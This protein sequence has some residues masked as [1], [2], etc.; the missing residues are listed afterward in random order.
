MG[1]TW[2]ANL[3]NPAL[4]STSISKSISPGLYILNKFA[5]SYAHLKA[6]ELSS[7][8]L[9]FLELF[10]I[11]KETTARWER[12]QELLNNL[13]VYLGRGNKAHR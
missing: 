2:G 13:A 4:G 12:I 10:D 5:H 1:Q 11:S 9:Q 3:D 8:L 6:S 7:A